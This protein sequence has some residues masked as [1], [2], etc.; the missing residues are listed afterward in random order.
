[1]IRARIS[2]SVALCLLA[3]AAALPMAAEATCFYIYNAKNE[4][5]YRSTLSPVDL[6]R[7][8]SA[9]LRGR[10]EGGHL[11]MVPSNDDCIDLAVYGPSQEMIAANAAS[12]RNLSP[13]EASP[14]FRNIESST[15]LDGYGGSQPSPAP[16]PRGAGARSGR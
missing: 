9:G 14:L 1:M 7:P 15:A 3:A 16:S 5:V 6:S 4:L 2:S 12:G 10:Y 13:I 8:I 11:T